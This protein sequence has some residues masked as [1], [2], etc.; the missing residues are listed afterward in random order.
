MNCEQARH[1]WHHALDTGETDDELEAHLAACSSCHQYAE[2]MGRVVG[3]LDEL[4]DGSEPVAGLSSAVLYAHGRLSPQ[5]ASRWSVYRM[6]RIAAMIA[7]VVTISAYF[8]Y[9]NSE[10]VPS[11]GP[12]ITAGITPDRLVFSGPSSGSVSGH[13][14]AAKRLLGITLRGGSAKRYV[15]VST[16]SGGSSVQ[17][18]WLYRKL[19]G[20]AKPGS[21]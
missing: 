19:P 5:P 8:A 13:A 20:E 16:P 3:A 18:Y 11:A 12:G 10:I 14:P 6:G 21:S 1:R 2:E 17:I 15:A 7:V 9:Q 4:R